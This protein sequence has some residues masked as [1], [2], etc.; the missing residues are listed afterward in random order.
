MTSSDFNSPF[1][2]DKLGP[3]PKKIHFE[4]SEAERKMLCA[5]FELLD[6]LSFKA[7][8]L[9]QRIKGKRIQA[10]YTGQVQITQQCVI[11]FKDVQSTLNF[12]FIRLYE[13]EVKNAVQDK[14][15]DVDSQSTDEVDLI[16]EG[17]IDLL[18]ALCEELGLDIDPHPRVEGIQFN[19]FGVGPEITEEE[20]QENNPFSVL[21]GLNQTKTKK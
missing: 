4:A 15:I 11:T 8:V 20:V 18:D 13:P 9:L 2:V 21:A 3:H 14:E 10:H 6:M 19:E 5:R 7:S 17:K 1:D 12:D 16:V